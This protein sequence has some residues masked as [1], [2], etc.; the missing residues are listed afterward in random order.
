MLERDDPGDREKAAVLLDEG[1]TI[2]SELGMRP[3]IERIQSDAG[4]HGIHRH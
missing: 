2:A 1:L 3:L 4:M